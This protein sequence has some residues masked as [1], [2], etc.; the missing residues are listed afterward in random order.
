MVCG[1]P[2]VTTNIPAHLGVVHDGV[3]AVLVPPDDPEQLAAAIASL[4]Q[5]PQL[6][7]RLAR[8]TREKATREHALPEMIARHVAL[9]ADLSRSTSAR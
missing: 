5:D 1:V 6:A 3:D 2:V 9:F 8:A 4:F 7:E